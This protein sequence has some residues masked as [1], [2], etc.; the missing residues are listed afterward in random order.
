LVAALPNLVFAFPK[1]VAALPKLVGALF[2]LDAAFS[3]LVAAL[4]KFDDAL[5]KL[6]SAFPKLLS[7]FMA[8]F[9]GMR[10]SIANA[11]GVL[12]FINGLHDDRARRRAL[13]GAARLPRE[14]RGFFKSIRLQSN[15]DKN[16]RFQE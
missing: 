11:I 15:S 12:R 14:Q 2:N 8:D 4:L 7:A 6:L 5:P 9:F 13:L 10:R 16:A 3:D 1:A